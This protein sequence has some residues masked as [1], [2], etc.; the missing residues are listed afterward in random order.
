MSNKTSLLNRQKFSTIFSVST[1]SFSAYLLVLFIVTDWRPTELCCWGSKYTL[2]SQVPCKVWGPALWICNLIDTII[3]SAGRLSTWWISDSLL[4]QHSNENN[5]ESTHDKWSL[6]KKDKLTKTS[7]MLR[8]QNV[9]FC[10]HNSPPLTYL[11][12]V[13]V[14]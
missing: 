3:S 13:Y 8:C 12:N 9:N 6:E 4:E 11:D 7:H 2:F 10:Q 5:E 1:W 14:L